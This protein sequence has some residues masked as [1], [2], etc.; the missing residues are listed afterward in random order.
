M[1]YGRVDNVLIKGGDCEHKVDLSFV[2][3][4]DNEWLSMGSVSAWVMD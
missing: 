4:V 2:V 1:F 3:Q